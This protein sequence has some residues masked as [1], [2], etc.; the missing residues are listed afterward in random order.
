M[1]DHLGFTVADYPRSRAF[2]ER[3]LAPL[4]YG[5]VMD[6]TREMSDGYEGCGFGPPG[7]PAFWVG[8]GTGNP[9]QGLHIAF[10]AKSRAE[11]DAFHAAALDAGAIDNGAPGLRPHYHTN[12]YGAFVIDPDG[13]NIEA[14]CHAP[15]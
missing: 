15:E 2:Y 12:Y 7:K 6:V 3:A 13:H 8:T 1:L 10:V 11:V 4:G 14:V 5:V 9:G